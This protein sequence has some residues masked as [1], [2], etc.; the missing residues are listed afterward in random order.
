[1]SVEYDRYLSEHIGGVQKGWEWM[2]ANLLPKMSDW[3]KANYKADEFDP[4]DIFEMRELVKN[5]DASKTEP[6]EYYFY[7]DYFYLS[8]DN[9]SSEVVNNFHRA[10]LIHMHRNPHHWQYWVLT[11]DN[12]G[13]PERYIEMPLPYIFEMI[14]D[15]WSFSWRSGDLTEIFKW[16]DE[17]KTHIRLHK[18]SRRTVEKILEEM[19]KAMGVKT[20]ESSVDISKEELAHSDKEEEDNPKKF[21]VP[22]IKK[23]PM[24]DADHVRSAIRFFNYIDPKYEKELAEAI[25]ER[26][27]EYGVD[28]DEMT[29]GDENR[30]KNYISEGKKA[31]E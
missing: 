14:C 31:E 15:W 1:M 17:H 6:D 25:L 30:F 13:E 28:L 10:F 7:D 9:R 11:S 3:I 20:E 19:K 23:Y 4:I 29:I 5:H 16:W 21:G 24:P 22:E 12:A 2:E 26:A 27:K 8:K 18:K